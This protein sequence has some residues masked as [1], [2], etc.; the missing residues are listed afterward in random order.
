MQ[1]PVGIEDDRPGGAV[2]GD[3]ARGTGRGVVE[4]DDRGLFEVA[5]L[6]GRDGEPLQTPVRADEF[7]GVRGRGGAQH[8]RG[9]V[10]LLDAPRAVDGDAVAEP[11]RL[12][13]VVG[14]EEDRLAERGLKPQELVLEVLA[15]HRVDRAERLVHQQ[16]GRVG[17]ER[18][19]HPDA[20]ALAAGELVGIAVAVRRRVQADQVE[21]FGGTRPGLRPRPAEQMRDGG[22]V[23]QDGLVGEQPHLLDDVADTAPQLDGVEGGYVLAVEEDAA[24]GGLDE[25]VDHLHRRGLAAPRRPDERD[26]FTLGDLEGEVVHGG[27]AVG[28]ALGDV[29]EADHSSPRCGRAHCGRAVVNAVLHVDGD[30]A[31]ELPD[32]SD[33]QWRGLGSQ[34]VTGRV[35]EWGGGGDGP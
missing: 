25:P 3:P 2:G 31:R 11:D 32:R 16:H 17:G 10:E 19:G 29:L 23:V 15:H 18:A 20:L 9:G 14:D 6:D 21:E 26:E 4:A 24:A 28:V 12:L 33:C 22:G 34:T 1:R 7:G 5:G 35:S 30:V 13:D 27:G 8:G